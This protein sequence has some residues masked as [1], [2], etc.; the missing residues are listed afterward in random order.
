MGT[1]TCVQCNKNW[2][3]KGP[4]NNTICDDCSQPQ[5][6]VQDVIND[7]FQALVYE[8]LT[9]EEIETLKHVDWNEIKLMAA[10]HV[11]LQL[12]WKLLKIEK[13]SAK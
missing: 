7:D 12:R 6:E 1:M 3:E 10:D 2:Y 9:D 11:A 8:V 5:E 4:S 13:G